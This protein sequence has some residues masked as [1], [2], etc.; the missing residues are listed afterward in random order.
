MH[1]FMM[2]LMYCQFITRF[3]AMVSLLGD[4]SHG[5]GDGGVV[6]Y[7]FISELVAKISWYMLV[8]TGDVI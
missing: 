7:D 3:H 8:D 1:N 5:F 4:L 6:W 2:S